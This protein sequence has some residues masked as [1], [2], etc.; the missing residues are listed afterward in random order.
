M[1]IAD[2]E[3]EVLIFDLFGVI[4]AFDDGLVVE[5]LAPHCA[6]P[7]DASRR[8]HKLTAWLDVITGAVTLEQVHQG[9]VDTH[10]LAMSYREFEAVWLEPYSWPIPGMAEL[11][12]KLSKHYRLVLLSNVDRDYWQVVRTMHPEL[13][14]FELRLVSCDLGMAKPDPEIYRQVSRLTGA[15]PPRCFFVDDTAAN[16]E[17]ARALGFH[18]YVFGSVEGLTTELQQA[19][20]R[21]L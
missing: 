10:G 9:L 15:E 1:R 3:I 13:E 19:N 7:A 21:G 18:G 6:D 8:L 4:I 12:A 20:A 11:V 2:S 5:R 14:R 17:A 16:V